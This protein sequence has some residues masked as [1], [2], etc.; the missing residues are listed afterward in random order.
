MKGTC[1]DCKHM[2]REGE[3]FFCIF[4]PPRPL[5]VPTGSPDERFNVLVAF[6]KIMPTMKCSQ[7]AIRLE[8]LS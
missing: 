6:P 1:A 3:D 2:E 8:L 4:N 5:I 7:H